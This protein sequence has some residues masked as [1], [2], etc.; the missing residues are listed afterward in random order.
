MPEGD[1]IVGIFLVAS[2]QCELN[3]LIYRMICIEGWL[4]LDVWVSR[5]P[6][7]RV[8]DLAPYNIG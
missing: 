1:F 3:G 2:E 5:S 7:D 6:L 4:W 8:G